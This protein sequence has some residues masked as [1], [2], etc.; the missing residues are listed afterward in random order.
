MRT[1]KLGL[2]AEKASIDKKLKF[3]ALV[4]HINVELLAECYKEVRR[5]AAC[6]IDGVT[7]EA[8]GKDLMANLEKLV[9]RLKSK[10]YRCRPVRRVYIPKP[11][12]KEQ[13]PLGILSLE[14][15]LV[16]MAVKK[17]LEMVFEPLFLECSHGFR[18]K[19]GCHTAIK[20]LNKAVMKAPTNYIVEVDIAKFFDTVN[21]HWL[22]RCLEERITDPNF[23]WLIRRFLKAGVMEDGI[24]KASK[25][26]TPQGGAVSPILANIYLH[27]VLDLWF[28]I[29]IQTKAQGRMELIRYC[30]D[31]VVA[32]ESEQDAHKFLEE[33]ERRLA[34]FNLEISKEKTKIVEFG[35]QAWKAAQRSGSKVG[36]FTF[37]GFTHYCK[38]SKNGWFMIAHKTSKERMRGKLKKV[39]DSLKKTR[40]TLTLR[41]WWEMLEKVLRGHYGYFGINGNFHCLRQFYNKVLMMVY[42]WMNRRSQKKSMN[43]E[44][45]LTYLRWNPLPKPRIVHQIW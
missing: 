24:W 23:L 18:P 37:L 32:C 41:D 2:I 39:N 17:I 8:Y 13:R 34:E 35:R 30:D 10:E 9:V 6:G 21:H 7:V 1:S 38:A 12:K 25:Q 31:F 27:Y 28:K 40:H 45:F 36:T 5:S 14:D 22:L 4:H 11:G 43:M 33:L 15:K 42:K 26:G 20:Q 3:N 16:Q 29:E 19:L 44:K